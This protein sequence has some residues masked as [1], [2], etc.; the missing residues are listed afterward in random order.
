MGPMSSAQK[1][2]ITTLE[3]RH[4][5]TIWLG[6][7]F[8]YLESC[9][10]EAD[11]TGYNSILFI[12]MCRMQQFLAFLRSFFHSSLLLLSPATLLNLLFFHALSVHLA[13]LFLVLPLG[14]VSKF[15]YNTLLGILF[16][17]ILCTC[18]NHCN[19]CSL[20]GSVMVLFKELHR[21]LY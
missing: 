19:L 16:S 6:F 1:C 13:I 5:I 14:L 11:S 18:P 20:I 3:K 8:V 15:I 2:S 4:H 9:N 7:Q 17:S 21:F 12:G 10:T